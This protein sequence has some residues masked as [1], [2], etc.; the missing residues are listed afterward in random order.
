MSDPLTAAVVRYQRTGTGREELVQ[1]TAVIVYRHL[2]GRR[3]A[4]EDD[5]GDFLCFFYPKIPHLFG[6][7]SYQ[8]KPFVHYL[9]VTVKMQF[10]SFQA[11]R[12]KEDA[13]RIFLEFHKSVLP[14]WSPPH[15]LRTAPS[16]HIR[17]KVE[18]VFGISGQEPVSNTTYRRRLLFLI[19]K[20]ALKIDSETVE[21]VAAVTGYEE[22]WLY[23]CIQKLKSKM[24]QK[25]ERIDTLRLKRNRYYLRVCTL[26]TQLTRAVHTIERQDLCNTLKNVKRLLMDTIDELSR[27]PT[28]PTHRDIAM[29]LGVPKGS[30]DSGLYYLKNAYLEACEKET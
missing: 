5:A 27:V 20:E 9:M 1:K 22:S 30:V 29:I 15:V 23:N 10:R 7:F 25:C 16:S 17:K 11:Q 12:R 28:T 21:Y 13:R 2:L 26:H 3:S 24:K 14:P 4:D 8:G 18:Q 19:M 6:R